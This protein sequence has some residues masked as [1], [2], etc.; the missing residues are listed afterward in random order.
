MLKVTQNMKWNLVWILFEV[1]P[2]NQSIN[3]DIYLAYLLQIVKHLKLS[4]DISLT[5][6][7]HLNKN[8]ITYPFP[9][10]VSPLKLRFLHLTP[11]LI[12]LGCLMNIR[13][14]QHL[15]FQYLFYSCLLFPLCYHS[16]LFSHHF[17]PELLQ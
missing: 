7:K 10:L 9:D 4:M 12:S 3:L 14:F 16:G 11:S 6:Q 1:H 15:F 5:E 13:K 8:L 2:P 17:L